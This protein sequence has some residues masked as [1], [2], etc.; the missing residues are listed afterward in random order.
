MLEIGIVG[1]A[2]LQIE[3][4][5]NSLHQISKELGIEITTQVISEIDV[6]LSFDANG[7]PFLVHENEIYFD[8]HFPNSKELREF[9]S[10]IA[11]ADE[12]ILK[13]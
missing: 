10:K 12:N 9:I 8:T 5:K 6:I 13:S 3:Q 1:I 11:H 2:Q 4:L 7:I